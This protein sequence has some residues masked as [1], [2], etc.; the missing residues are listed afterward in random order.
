MQVADVLGEG[1]ISSVV[2]CKHPAHPAGLA[3][4]M[5]HKDR[6]SNAQYS[7]ASSACAAWFAAPS[8]LC[9]TA[10]TAVVQV[11]QEAGTHSQLDNPGV[12]PLYAAFEDEDGV[13]LAQELVTGK[14]ASKLV[15]ASGGHLS[16]A[17]AVTAIM[18]PLVSALCH[19]HSKVSS[20]L[21]ACRQGHSSLLSS[22]CMQG[23]LHRDVKTENLLMGKAGTACLAD[24]G[25]T[26]SMQAGPVKDCIGTLDYQAPEVKCPCCCC[27]CRL[28]SSAAYEQ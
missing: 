22:V 12:V 27:C 6:M 23:L 5:Y 9:D 17:T 20:L 2:S 25:E 28:L 4:K 7:K 15:H 26:C 18:R 16:E 21:L 8:A 3:V 11:L 24:F 19:M 1:A 13:Y 14:N 10:T